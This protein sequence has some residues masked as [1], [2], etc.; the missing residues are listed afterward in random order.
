MLSA[1]TL[2]QKPGESVMPVSVS[3]QLGV[4]A[5][6]AVPILRK[7]IATPD[8]HAACARFQRGVTE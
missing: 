3:G 5:A 6:F 8:H 4:G 7:V 1:K 2:A